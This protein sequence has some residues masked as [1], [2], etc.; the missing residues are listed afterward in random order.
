MKDFFLVSSVSVVAIVSSFPLRFTFVDPPAR[1]WHHWVCRLSQVSSQA[2][3]R[4]RNSCG[5]ELRVK[6][7]DAVAEVLRPLC[8][9]TLVDGRVHRTSV[10]VVFGLS[11]FLQPSVE[12]EVAPCSVFLRSIV[13]LSQRVLNF[14][15]SGVWTGQSVLRGT[16][17]DA[18]QGCSWLNSVLEVLKCHLSRWTC[19]LYGFA[20]VYLQCRPSHPRVIDL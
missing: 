9:T 17:V 16:V 19:L 6:E 18:V 2:P 3:W 11:V 8:P 14:D 20:A 4:C 13:E 10:S 12:L 15:E 7:F 1:P 5:S